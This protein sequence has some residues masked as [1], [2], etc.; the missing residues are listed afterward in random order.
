MRQENGRT[1]MEGV[2]IYSIP[3][4]CR[5]LAVMEGRAQVDRVT[6]GTVWMPRREPLANGFRLRA[7]ELGYWPIDPRAALC[8]HSLLQLA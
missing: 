6:R 7:A 4:S 2:Y 3:T 5:W 1:V 8:C